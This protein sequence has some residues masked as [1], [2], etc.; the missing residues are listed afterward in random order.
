[1]PICID[2]QLCK[3]ICHKFGQ[4]YC[5]IVFESGTIN[6]ITEYDDLLYIEVGLG[7]RPQPDL[8]VVN[9]SA[10]NCCDGTVGLISFPPHLQ[11]GSLG[12]VA[13]LVDAVVEKTI[14]SGG[15]GRFSYTS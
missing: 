15:A 1:M 7:I 12:S 13:P 2:K 10:R 3:N 9:S 4:V 5:E 11:H 14:P 8:P 6:R